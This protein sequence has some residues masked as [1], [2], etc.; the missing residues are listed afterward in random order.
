MAADL[1]GVNTITDRIIGCAYKVMQSLGHGFVE[2]VYENA[3][4]VELK[5]AGLHA[6]QQR[7]DQRV[8]LGKPCVGKCHH[9]RTFAQAPACDGDRD[10]GREQ[11]ELLG[12]QAYRLDPT[13]IQ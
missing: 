9:Q 8:A 13:I 3:L 10:N 2:K 11:V 4:A 7:D 1:G 12:R 6:E 5:T